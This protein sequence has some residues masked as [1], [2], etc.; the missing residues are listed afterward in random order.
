MSRSRFRSATSCALQ[1]GTACAL[2]LAGCSD[3][4][5][6]GAGNAPDTGLVASGSGVTLTY[7]NLRSTVGNDCPSPG[8]P[9]GVISL[10]IES[11]QTDGTG[12]FTLCVGRPDLLADDAQSLGCD[13][14]GIAARIIDFTGTAGGCSFV[15]DDEAPVTGDATSTGLCGNGDDPAGFALTVG[16]SATVIRTCGTTVDSVVVN[17]S[18]RVAV[19]PS[20]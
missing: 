13:L 2:A 8:A 9:A 19:R 15:F 11:S 3:D 4:P 14:P 7:G 1:I 5:T 16:G 17:L 18:G 6:C 20:T 10:T 12:L